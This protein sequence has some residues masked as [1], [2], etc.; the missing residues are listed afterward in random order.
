MVNEKKQIEEFSISSIIKGIYMNISTIVIL[1]LAQIVSYN[2]NNGI[3]ILHIIV[4]LLFAPFY[5][6]WIIAIKQMKIKVL[7]N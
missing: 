5:L 7:I 1:I 4:A 2:Y 6:F 3:N